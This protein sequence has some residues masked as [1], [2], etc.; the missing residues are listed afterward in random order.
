MNRKNHGENFLPETPEVTFSNLSYCQALSHCVS[1]LKET[2]LRTAL[3]THLCEG[4]F[5]NQEGIL[6]L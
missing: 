5:F 2:M 3:T 4:F 6:H 1:A